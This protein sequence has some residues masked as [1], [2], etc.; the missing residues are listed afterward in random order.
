MTV[1]AVDICIN[2][3]IY[4]IK[5]AYMVY[6]SGFMA[7]VSLCPSP[8]LGIPGVSAPT[9]SAGPACAPRPRPTRFPR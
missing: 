4:R 2:F 3:E 8:V 9:S 6:K 1:N 7:N 5:R